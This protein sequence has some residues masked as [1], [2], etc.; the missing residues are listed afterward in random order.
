MVGNIPVYVKSHL[1][2]LS[3][4]VPACGASGCGRSPARRMIPE[5]SAIFAVPG[6]SSSTANP[7]LGGE[8]GALPEP[9]STLFDRTPG[10][11]SGSGPWSV[12]LRWIPGQAHDSRVFRDLRGPRPPGRPM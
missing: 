10:C 1:D 6:R 7:P 4:A 12:G 8:A 9:I 5:F 11:L 2:Y 3:K